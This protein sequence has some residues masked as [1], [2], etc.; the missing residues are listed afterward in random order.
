MNVSLFYFGLS[1]WFTMECNTYPYTF[2][3]LIQKMY[4]YY[5]VNCSG[6]YKILSLY[7]NRIPKQLKS[8][9]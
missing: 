2:T 8:V 6:Y 9:S 4:L 5:N 1:S 3:K 7:S